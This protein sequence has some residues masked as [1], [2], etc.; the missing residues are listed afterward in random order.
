M[1]TDFTNVDCTSDLYPLLTSRFHANSAVLD[2][3]F[4]PDTKAS[5]LHRGANGSHMRTKEFFVFK[6]RTCASDY[7][8]TL[9]LSGTRQQHDTTLVGGRD[10]HPGSGRR[11]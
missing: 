5:I 4:V 11:V 2:Q 3:V 7:Y 9:Q 8:F 10:H 1:S 6:M